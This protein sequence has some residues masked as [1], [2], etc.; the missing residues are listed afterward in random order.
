[1]HLAAVGRTARVTPPLIRGIRSV[2]WISKRRRQVKRQGIAR[3]LVETARDDGV[4]GA[5]V[6][7]FHPERPVRFF[8][9]FDANQ[10]PPKTD[11]RAEHPLLSRLSRPAVRLRRVRGRS[12]TVRGAV[13]RAAARRAK[14]LRDGVHARASVVLLRAH[15]TRLHDDPT[16]VFIWTPR[17]GPAIITPP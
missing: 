1:M 7:G 8:E 9:Y 14:R 5:G 10:F 12:A 4:V 3:G 17:P 16:N 15:H 13:P 6:H 11:E 2:G